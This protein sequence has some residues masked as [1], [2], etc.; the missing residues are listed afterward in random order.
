MTG[1]DWSGIRAVLFDLDETLFDHRAA[2][3]EGFRAW[4]RGLGLGAYESR[5]QEW[6]RLETLYFERFERGEVDFRQQ[7]RDRVRDFLGDAG[8]P[9]DEAESIFDDYLACYRGEWRAFADAAPAVRRCAA[10][11]LGVAVVTNGDLGQQV[12][13][14]AA[15][16]IPVPEGAVFVSGAVGHSKPSPE[17]FHLACRGLE[18]RPEEGLMVGDN[19]VKD[20]YGARGAGLAAV[21]LDRSGRLPGAIR[22]LDELRPS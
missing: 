7:R 11:G 10:A 13:K 8:L 19:L 1:V 20:Y 18:V 5:A 2:A 9:D 15:I 6:M 22:S 4:A 12:E 14:L 21:L 3:E 17:I 16:G